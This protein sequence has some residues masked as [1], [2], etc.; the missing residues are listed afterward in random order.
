MSRRGQAFSLDRSAGREEGWRW[1]DRR[2]GCLAMH[3]LCDKC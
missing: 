2:G 3:C 1:S